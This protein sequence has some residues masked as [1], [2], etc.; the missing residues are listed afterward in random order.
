MTITLDTVRL[1]IEKNEDRALEFKEAREGIDD[2]KLFSYCVGIANAGG[3]YLILG[4]S[5]AIP[6]KVVGTKAFNNIGRKEAQLYQI[7]KFDV[8]IQEFNLENGRIVVLSIPGRPKGSVYDYEGVYYMR[9]GDALVKMTSDALQAVFKET[10]EHWLKE[11]AKV[12]LPADRVLDLLDG[13]FYYEQIHQREPSDSRAILTLLK[14]RGL[15]N[16]SG[17]LYSITRI[18]A[19]MLCRNFSDFPELER[20]SP[21]VIIYEGDNRLRAK[22]DQ[23]GTRGYAL[24][25]SSLIKYVKTYIPVREFYNKDGKREAVGLL[26]ELSLRELLIN[27][28]IHQDFEMNSSRVMIEVFSDRVEIS[29]P[30]TPIIPLNRFIDFSASRNEKLVDRMRELKLCE[31]RSSGIDK[32]ISEAEGYK[33]VAPEFIQHERVIVVRAFGYKAFKDMSREEK[34]RACVQHCILCSVAGSPL[35]LMTNQT[36]RE[37]FGLNKTGPA[38]AGVSQ[39]IAACIKSGLIKL[40]PNVGR[41]RKLAR[42]LPTWA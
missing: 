17:G 27:A 8:K 23:T 35:K 15:I 14:D 32:V 25:F 31:E 3:G 36:L 9:V 22:Q 1:W 26:P 39:T 34:M 12:N 10:K 11:N 19:V 40:D 42:Y 20:K 13:V 18:A 41:S 2:K 5:D 37:R 4:V 16:E 21:R 24:A 28:L 30:G 29:N 38:Q 33:L 6:R 7:L